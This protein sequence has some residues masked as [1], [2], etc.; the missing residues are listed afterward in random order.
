MLFIFVF[1]MN[2]KRSY[3][4]SVQNRTK[5]RGKLSPK[6]TGQI[7]EEKFLRGVQKMFHKVIMQLTEQD[8]IIPTLS[9]IN[10]IVGNENV[11]NFNHVRENLLFSFLES[12]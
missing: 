12:I 7:V 8:T 4:F 9:I 3:E 10:R 5:S 1:M 11:N 2:L 6:V